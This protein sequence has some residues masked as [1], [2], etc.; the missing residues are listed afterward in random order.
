MT[1][2]TAVRTQVV[3][4]LLAVIWLVASAFGAESD[5]ILGTYVPEDGEVGDWIRDGQFEVATNLETLAGLI[6]GAAPQY[7]DSGVQ[8]VVFQEY[9]LHDEAYLTL[10]LYRAGSVKEAQ[11]LYGNLYLDRPTTLEHT[12]DQAR[13]AEQLFG[14]Y[15]LELRQAALFVR[16]TVSSKT[17]QTKSA[18]LAFAQAVLERMQ[19]EQVS[20]NAE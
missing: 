19:N 9:V 10:E 6:N 11:Q 2:C 3:K 12:G 7:I 17:E 4:S 1:A 20:G 5:T 14:V 16:I 13:M 8:E 18:V 15:V